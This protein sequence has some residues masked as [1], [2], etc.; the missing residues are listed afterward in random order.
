MQQLHPIADYVQ[1]PPACALIFPPKYL[2]LLPFSV[3]KNDDPSFSYAL[4]KY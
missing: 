1:Q 2:H 4:K 3:F